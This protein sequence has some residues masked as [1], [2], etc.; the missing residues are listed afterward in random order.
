MAKWCGKIGFTNTVEIKPGIW[1]T[2]VVEKQ[3]FGDVLDDRWKRQSSGNVNDDINI[4]N[5]ISILADPYAMNHCSTMTYIEFM[6]TNWK[7]SDVNV[8]YP[9]L[10]INIGGVYNG[11]T[12]RATN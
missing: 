2:E 6:G 4:S 3:Y 9:R 11:D 5:R 10:V 7:I 12:A 1:D 8:Q